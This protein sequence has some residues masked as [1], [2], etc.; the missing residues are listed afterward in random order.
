MRASLAL[1]MTVALV[2]AACATSAV[3]VRDDR[4][5]PARSKVGFWTLIQVTTGSPRKVNAA[6]PQRPL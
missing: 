3:A 5:T 2:A 6:N 1:V 4:I